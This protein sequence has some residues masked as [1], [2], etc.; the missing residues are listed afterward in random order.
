MELKTFEDGSSIT[1]THVIVIGAAAA[2]GGVV[3]FKVGEWVSDKRTKRWMKKNNWYQEAID[4][5]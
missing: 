5:Y 3:L 1:G 2:I 4:R